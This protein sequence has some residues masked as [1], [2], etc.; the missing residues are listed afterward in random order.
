MDKKHIV[1]G[2]IAFNFSLFFSLFLM[3]TDKAFKSMILGFLLVMKFAG[4]LYLTGI[5]LVIPILIFLA[6]LF[7]IKFVIYKKGKGGIFVVVNYILSFF[8]LLTCI[9]GISLQ[10]NFEKTIRFYDSQ[11][12]LME[13]IEKRLVERNPDFNLEVMDVLVKEGNPIWEGKENDDS[14]A[15]TVFNLKVTSKTESGVKKIKK[16][17]YMYEGRQLQIIIDCYSDG[18]CSISPKKN[19]P[20][21]Y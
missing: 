19:G 1:I 4:A 17:D 13:T 2:E 18:K 21:V 9:Y 5:F 3:F 7:I 20:I 15:K 14:Y 6:A 11:E 8:I 16:Y 10:T 12:N